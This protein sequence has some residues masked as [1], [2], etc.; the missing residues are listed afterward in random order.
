MANG[1]VHFT[2]PG[3]WMSMGV[4]RPQG[5]YTFDVSPTVYIIRF[6][7]RRPLSNY[8]IDVEPPPYTFIIYGFVYGELR[9]QGI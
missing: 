2:G 5:E 7:D 8:L 3:Y 4:G 9:L 6:K 1:A